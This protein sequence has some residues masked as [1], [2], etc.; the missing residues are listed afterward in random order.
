MSTAHT[1]GPW[2]VNPIQLDQ[3]CTSDAKC[4]IAR[5]MILHPGASTFANARL[6]ALAPELLQM[7]IELLD[8]M[9]NCDSAIENDARDLIA[10]VTGETP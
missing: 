10:K 8:S 9:G 2:V 1:P 7:V 3:V 4:V 6:I 5:A